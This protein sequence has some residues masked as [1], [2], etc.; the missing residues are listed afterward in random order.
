MAKNN[1]VPE[2]TWADGLFSLGRSIQGTIKKVKQLSDD[3]FRRRDELEAISRALST[4]GLDKFAPPQVIRDDL[5][6]QC[7]QRTA[8]FWQQFAEACRKREWALHGTTS[9]RILCRSIFIELNGEAVLVEGIAGQ[10][11][12]HVETLV[13]RLT[14]EVEKVLPGKF[15]ASE[16]VSLIVRAYDQMAGVSVER[17]L[18]DLYRASVL[19]GQKQVFWRNLD[20]S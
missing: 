17:P 13:E 8:E 2:P 6:A 1:I 12:P 15:N 19:L 3:P 14:P 4:L 16:F 9:R 5:S 18:E 7:I 10:L 20:V 11:T